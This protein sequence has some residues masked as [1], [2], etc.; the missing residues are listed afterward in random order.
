MTIEEIVSEIIQKVEQELPDEGAQANEVYELAKD[1]FGEENVDFQKVDN[2]TLQAHYFQYFTIAQTFKALGLDYLL[3]QEEYN[4]NPTASFANW[5]SDLSEVGRQEFLD[6]L[7]PEVLAASELPRFFVLV[8]FQNFNVTNE[9]EDS[10]PIEEMFTKTFVTRDGRATQLR[11]KWARTKTSVMHYLS[12]YRHSHLSSYSGP[13]SNSS[14]MPA[15]AEFGDPCLGQGPIQVTLSTLRSEFN[16]VVWRLYWVELENCIQV[17]SLQGGPY[18]KMADIISSNLVDKTLT[19]FYK[20]SWTS[21]NIPDNV[22]QLAD[23]VLK[24]KLIDW[25]WKISHIA[26]RQNFIEFTLVASNAFIDMN[27][28]GMEEEEARAVVDRLLEDH[29]LYKAQVTED[30]IYQLKSSVSTESGETRTMQLPWTFKGQPV[31]FSVI[32]AVSNRQFTLLK[33][34]IVSQLYYYLIITAN[35]AY[36]RRKQ[37]RC[38][39]AR[40]LQEQ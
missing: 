5:Y 4:T 31:E 35:I 39:E 26:P 29:T 18:I 9:E 38:R 19:E 37:I 40:N 36:G 6:R 33:D 12:G 11:V 3:I 27:T 1:Y 10:V 24:H 8:R 25:L 22:K 21:F 15:Y 32:P 7:T 14:L 23:Y 34:L 13:R 20:A 28:E 2:Y 30:K 16:P 17:E